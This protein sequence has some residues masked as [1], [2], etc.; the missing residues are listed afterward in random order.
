[1]GNPVL[2][3]CS[4][5]TVHLLVHGTRS[6]GSSRRLSRPVDSVH[7]HAASFGRV[8]AAAAVVQS[9][10][11]TRTPRSPW[12]RRGRLIMSLERLEALQKMS[13][14]QS[15]MR[16]LDDD[17]DELDEAS[18]FAEHQIA[19]VTEPT[20]Q[21][22]LRV[23]GVLR[24]IV[25]DLNSGGVLACSEPQ[26]RTAARFAAHVPALVSRTRS[27]LDGDDDEHQML[28]ISTRK[29]E[30]LL[31]ADLRSNAAILVLQNRLGAACGWGTSAL[32]DDDFDWPDPSSLT[33]RS[34][35][36]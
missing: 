35:E 10:P 20:M 36:F 1:M 3:T 24:V 14:R 15:L 17:D 31:T 32:W 19:S 34:L 11:C 5:H 12:S 28:N 9:T 2:S 25:I 4:V 23:P 7:T 8:V 33:G 18:R 30:M 21:R 13:S 22:L 27:L 26:S 29:F 6:A 16:G